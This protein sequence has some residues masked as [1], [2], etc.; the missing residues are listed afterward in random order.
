MQAHDGCKGKKRHRNRK[1]AMIHIRKL[2]EPG[3]QP[4][5][6]KTC[7]GWHIGHASRADGIQ[8]RLDRLLGPDPRT[9][10]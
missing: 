7:K 6:C 1:G 8:S 5:P 2:K 4:Y 10:P 9:Q 3:M